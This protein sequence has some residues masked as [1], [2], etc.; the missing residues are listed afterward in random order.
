M[1]QERA[2][3]IVF[4]HN[5]Q[6]RAA[7]VRWMLEEC[8]AD[9]EIRHVDFQKGD[10]KAPE[11]LALNP[12]GKIPTIVVGDT[13]ITEAAG[14]H[15]LARRRLSRCRAR[16]AAGFPERGTYYR[17]LFFG[18]SCIEPAMVDEMFKRPPPGA[19]A[20]SAGAATA[21]WSTRSNKPSSQ[22]LPARRSLQRGRCLCGGGTRLGGAVGCGAGA[23]TR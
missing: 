3:R 18:G 22:A 17:W 15:R 13:V 14:D 11:F 7:I 21:T 10:H 8:G 9:Y 16:P 2:S 23:D 6:S 5:P 20:L 4:Y 1:P 19:K 12:M